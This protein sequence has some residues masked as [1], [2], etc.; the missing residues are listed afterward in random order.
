M[1]TTKLYA[2]LCGAFLLG[3]ATLAPAQTATQTA[4][5]TTKDPV[6]AT[7]DAA[8]DAAARTKGVASRGT[9]EVASATGMDKSAYTAEREKIEAD[10]KAA[11]QK[12]D[13][14]KGNAQ[15]VCK[16]EAKY[17]E[18]AKKADLEV[19]YKGTTDAKYDG[20]VKKAKAKHDLEKQKCHDLK[21]ADQTACKKQAKAD[22]QKAIAAAK[23]ERG[24][25][26]KV[27]AAPDTSRATTEK[28]ASPPSSMAPSAT[29]KPGSAEGLP[30]ESDKKSPGK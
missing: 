4:P 2:A 5:K 19:K 15:D 1:K 11:K 22:E 26:K 24:S 7:K 10:F 21:G 18:Q 3:A 17:E 25:T 29:P 13:P 12:C 23:S 30:K 27:A 6:T 8:G 28:K 16:A 9:S 14:L 20:A